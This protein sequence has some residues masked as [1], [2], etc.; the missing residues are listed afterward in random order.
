MTAIVFDPF[1]HV[2]DDFI[3]AVVSVAAGMPAPPP[4]PRSNVVS[5]DAA[6]V[7]RTNRTSSALRKINAKLNRLR[8][9][10]RGI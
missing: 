2:D 3:E 8:K 10:G 6:P 1:D 4:P 7:V 9:A 5:I